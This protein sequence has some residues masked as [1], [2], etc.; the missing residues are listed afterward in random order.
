MKRKLDYRAACE[1]EGLTIFVHCLHLGVSTAA[2][3]HENRS[4]KIV[5][6]FSAPI[7]LKVRRLA[8]ST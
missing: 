3:P 5:E 7:C 4:P 6:D 1:G 8:E 2:A